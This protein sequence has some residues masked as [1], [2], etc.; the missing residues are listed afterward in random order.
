[1]EAHIKE[2]AAYFHRFHALWTPTLLILD[3]SGVERLRN[4][5]FLPKAEFRAW[6]Q[7]ALGR[8]AFIQM[9]WSDASGLFDKVLSDHRHTHITPEAMYWAGVSRYKESHDG[10]WLGKTAEALEEAFP[11]S[12]WAEKASVWL[13]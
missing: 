12:L 11:R 6:L 7:F 13:S 2:R 3:G 5:G 4:E 10:L 1:M 8:F 9:R